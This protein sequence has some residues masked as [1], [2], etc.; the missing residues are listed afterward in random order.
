M[1]RAGHAG[2]SSIPSH[3]AFIYRT[4]SDRQTIPDVSLFTAPFPHHNMAEE[5]LPYACLPSHR[6]GKCSHLGDSFPSLSLIVQGQGRDCKYYCPGAKSVTT[7]LFH[8][9]NLHSD[10]YG[11]HVRHLMNNV[12]LVSLERTRVRGSRAQLKRS[13]PSTPA[14]GTQAWRRDPARE[15]LQALTK[16][17]FPHQLPEDVK[18]AVSLRARQQQVA[19]LSKPWQPAG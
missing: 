5:R 10:T 15:T 3:S 1:W 6:E 14:A 12:S 17:P 2:L 11:N 13:R 9:R 19:A 8:Q 4:Q 7:C 16:G 18:A